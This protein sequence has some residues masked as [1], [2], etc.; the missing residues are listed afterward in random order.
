[1]LLGAAIQNEEGGILFLSGLIIGP[2]VGHF[3]AGQVGRGLGTMGLRAG[4]TV[5]GLYWLVACMD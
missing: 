5:A 3:Y 1:M 2:S 4:G